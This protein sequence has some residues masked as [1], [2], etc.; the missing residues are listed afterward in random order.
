MYKSNIRPDIIPEFPNIVVLALTNVC[1]HLC[2][3]CQYRFYSKRE[4]YQLK[5][6]N[7]KIFQKIVDEMAYYKNAYLRLCAWGEPLLHPQIVDFVGYASSR[8]VKT[9]LL[10]N[11]YPL[12]SDL[13][14]QL[15]EAGLTMAEISIDAA[16]DSTYMKVRAN[17]QLNT[18]EIVNSNVL[19]FKE[20]INKNHFF[21]KVVVSYVT[22]PNNESEKEF[23]LFKNKWEPYVD[24]IVKRRLHSFMC[25]VNT[26]FIKLP[27]ERLPCYGLWARGVVNPWGKIVICYN[28]WEIDKW[29][30]ADLNDEGVNIHK[31]WVGEEY[32]FARMRKEQVDGIFTG[33]CANCKDYNPYAWEH[34][35]EE[36]I[37]KIH[38]AQI[39]T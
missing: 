2:N 26:D 6:M 5:H 34:P 22:W 15:A 24:N 13:S 20:I 33:P 23:V 14:Y 39:I 11:G 1:T 35:F 10:S 4:D 25:A 27:E 38:T 9:I 37:Q 28:Q 18:F 32:A 8:N 7:E 31:V 29:E 21:T 16:K 19:K 3:H 17:D 36:V 12:N 30:I